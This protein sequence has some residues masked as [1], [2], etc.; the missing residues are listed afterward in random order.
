MHAAMQQNTAEQQQAL[1]SLTEN[2]LE[3]TSLWSSPIPELKIYCQFRRDPCSVSFS[4]AKRPEIEN[5]SIDSEPPF[6]YDD[7]LPRA[8]SVCSRRPVRSSNGLYTARP[9]IQ[10]VLCGFYPG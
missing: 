10:H 7:L 4:A 2:L 9:S 3:Y 6:L 5:L 1:I 8:D